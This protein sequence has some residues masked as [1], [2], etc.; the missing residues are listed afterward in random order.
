MGLFKKKKDVNIGVS[1][2]VQNCIYN[3]KN[4]HCMADKITVGPMN[5]VNTRDTIC[6][7]FEQRKDSLT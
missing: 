2:D 6:A 1:C 7:T 5:A 3:D 4:F